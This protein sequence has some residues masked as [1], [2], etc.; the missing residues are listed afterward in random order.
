METIFYQCSSVN[1]GGVYYNNVLLGMM[2]MNCGFYKCKATTRGGGILA[3]DCHHVVSKRVC[4]YNCEAALGPGFVMWSDLCTNLDTE[5]NMTSEATISSSS[6]SSCPGGRNRSVFCFNNMS[7]HFSTIY[8]GGWHFLFMPSIIVSNN[9]QMINNTGSG[10]L[11]FEQNSNN[12]VFQRYCFIKN[13]SSS[14]VSFRRFSNQYICLSCC[15]F[16]MISDIPF[17]SSI[18]GSGN[19]LVQNSVFNIGISLD[20]QSTIEQVGNLYSQAH[21][22]TFVS[23]LYNTIVSWDYQAVPTKK[24]LSSYKFQLMLLCITLINT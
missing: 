15:T 12:Q 11:S 1:G 13:P 23:T 3:Q 5:I 20:H 4:Y 18:G 16:V 14:V 6:H 17:I 8:A 21:V 7:N 19:L 9:N 2:I 10:Y 24:Q 22:S